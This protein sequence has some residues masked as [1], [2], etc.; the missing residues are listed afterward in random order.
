[1]ANVGRLF[2]AAVLVAALAACTSAPPAATPPRALGAGEQWVPV[3]NWYV[4]GVGTIL[5]AGVGFIGEY[6]L[7]GSFADSR[8]VWMTDP[9]GSR[10][11][12]AWPNGYSARFS[13]KLELLDE[14]SRLVGGEG[15]LISGGCDTPQPGVMSVSLPGQR[16]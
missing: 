12:L 5:C 1:M 14:R 9:H 4:P 15:S 16:Q 13:P 3:A 10:I 11:E 2:A 8:L 6:R 7:H